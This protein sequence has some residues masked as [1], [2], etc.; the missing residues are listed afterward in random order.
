MKKTIINAVL[1]I[2]LALAGGLAGRYASLPLRTLYVNQSAGDDVNSCSEAKPCKTY[3]RAESLAAAGDVIRFVGV[4]TSQVTVL[5]DDVVLDGG[6]SAVIDTRAQNGIDIKK[7]VDHVT[8]R[9]FEVKSTRSHA[10]HI[11]GNYATVENNI[12]HHAI[13][14]NGAVNA[15]GS[16]T[17]YNTRWGSGIKTSYDVV[18]FVI[19]NNTV[20]DTCG[21]GIAATLSGDGVIENNVVY[22]NHNVN[23]YV[24]NSWNVQ[25]LNNVVTCAGVTGTDANGIATGEEG[26]SGYGALFH[27]V[28]IR[29]NTVRNCRN[30]INAF[31]SDVGGAWRNVIIEENFIPDGISFGI[32]VNAARCENSVIRNNLVW[33]NYIW[34]RC[35][36]GVEK[37]NNVK[38]DAGTVTPV[39][40]TPTRTPTRTPT[41]IIPATPTKTGQPSPTATDAGGC[42]EVRVGDIYVGDFCP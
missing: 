24:D 4:Y 37:I 33:T 16:M 41:P 5:K 3:G 28:L 8:V 12:V 21:E 34:T 15:D 14:E 11:E 25:V 18:G 7:G 32:A 31:S 35:S 26:Y 36:S 23:L 40:A 39:P 10:I 30:A 27:D 13:L 1:G 22:K 29:G 38:P 19:R 20:H 2:A 9:G 6:G 17:C 42:Y